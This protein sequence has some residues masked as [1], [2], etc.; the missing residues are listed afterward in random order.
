MLLLRRHQLEQMWKDDH[1]QEETEEQQATKTEEIPLNE[2]AEKT[3]KQVELAEV[4]E[5]TKT[6]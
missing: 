2:A 5:E 1:Q 4:Q 3:Q 6:N